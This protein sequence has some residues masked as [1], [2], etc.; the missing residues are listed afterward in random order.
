MRKEIKQEFLEQI[1]KD[2]LFGFEEPEEILE[3]VMNMFF[4]EDDLDEEWMRQKIITNF[5]KQKAISK[6]WTHP[7]DFDRLSKVFDQLDKMGIIALHKAGYTKQDGYAEVAEAKEMIEDEGFS[8]KGYCFYHT[9]DLSRAID[10][11]IKNL[12]IAFDSF[13]QNDKKAIEIGNQ[14][15]DLMRKEK[16]EIE[17]DGTIDQRIFIS[18]IQWQKVYDDDEWGLERSVN[19]I[20]YQ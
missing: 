11:E 10:P 3:G 13:D 2:I 20:C 14:I 12:F 1:Q 8:V 19:N 5:E 6:T 4:D 17:W 15:V 9:Q 7:T 16:F 18:K